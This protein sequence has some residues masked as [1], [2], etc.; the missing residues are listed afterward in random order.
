[1]LFSVIAIAK[2]LTE[3]DHRRAVEAGPPFVEA[4]E[5]Y[6]SLLSETGWQLTERL[7][8]TADWRRSLS[9][10]VKGMVESSELLDALGRDA[11]GEMQI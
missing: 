1:M 11:V 7:D 3:A 6:S 4:P 8:V 2:G 5:T 9:A 10:L